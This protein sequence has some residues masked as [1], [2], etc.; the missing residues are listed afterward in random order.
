MRPI[1]TLAL[2]WREELEATDGLKVG[3]AWQG[4]PDHKKDRLRS[5]RL[6]RFESL[7][8]IPGVRLFSLQKGFGSEQIEEAS[9]RFPI[10]DLG[11][12]LA[13]FMDAAA[14]V[15]QPRLAHPSRHR[16]G[17]P[18]RCPGGPGLGGGAFASDWRWLLE[19][20]DTP[21]YPTMRLFRQARWGDWDGVFERVRP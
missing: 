11:P 17:P 15:C 19:R 8:R 2:R 5:F 20:E 9:R 16:A 3:I 21:W 14:V 18:R 7:A 12:R 13:D 6:E 1:P 10:I 4:N